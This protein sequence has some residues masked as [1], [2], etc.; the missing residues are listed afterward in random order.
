MLAFLLVSQRQDCD[1]AAAF[2]DG[3]TRKAVQVLE[4]G[5]GSAAGGLAT[6]I[7]F[8]NEKRLQASPKDAQPSSPRPLLAFGSP[9]Q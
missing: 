2:R 7:G 3:G 4:N 6:I 8:Y 9:R 1:A 5:L